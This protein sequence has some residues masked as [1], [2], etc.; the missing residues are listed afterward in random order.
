MSKEHITDEP[1]SKSDD[2]VSRRSYLEAATVTGLGLAF[3]GLSAGSGSVRAATDVTAKDT[4]YAGKTLPGTPTNRD[5]FFDT[6][7]GEVSY[8]DGSEWQ[9]F[10]GDKTVW[11]V[12]SRMNVSNISADEAFNEAISNANDG[13]TILFRDGTYTLNNEYTI[14]KSLTL[15]GTGDARLELTDTTSGAQIQF[16]G[17]GQTNKANLTSVVEPGSRVIPV[18]DPSIFSVGD[19]VMIRNNN[20]T[21]KVNTQI[22]FSIVQDKLDTDG[23]GSVDSLELASA[24][25]YQFE[26]SANGGQ[27]AKVDLLDSPKVEGL[28]T[29][30]GTFGVF[31]FKWC[32][33]PVYEDVTVTDYVKMPTRAEDCWKPIWRNVEVRNPTQRGAGEGECVQIYRSTEAG[34]YS[35]RIYDCRRGI[36]LAWGSYGVTIVDPVIHN[37]SLHGISV[38]GPDIAGNVSVFGGTLVPDTGS[39]SQTGHGISGSPSAEFHVEGVHIKTRRTALLCNC[40]FTAKDVHIEPAEDVSDGQGIRVV[41]SDVHLEG[42]HIEDP[43]SRLS[44]APIHVRTK[45]TG[46]DIEN[47]TIDATIDT[48]NTPQVRVRAAE[49]GKTIDGLR[50]QGE[51]R[52]DSGSGAKAVDINAENS[53]ISR[54]DWSMDIVDHG[55]NCIVLAGAEGVEDFKLHDCTIK[56]SGNACFATANMASNQENDSLWIKN[57]Y[58]TGSSSVSIDEPTNNVWIVDNKKNNIHIGGEGSTV[59]NVVQRGNQ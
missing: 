1:N 59:T 15:K 34:V 33:D 46:E 26:D 9:V 14:T 32:E 36:D 53:R 19:R 51:I 47:V 52:S 10:Y 48:P 56:T 22:H 40:E 55:G 8:Y 37:F 58:L 20:Y 13:D 49:S 27:V 45:S 38:H 31:E 16:T 23:S 5:F 35:P 43:D 4:Y 6:G 44:I 21:Q 3:G 12:K 30:G 25:Y 29:F 11:D 50:F 57:C 2:G 41:H 42:I 18:D 28:T 24:T 7:T 39:N 54:V 17:G